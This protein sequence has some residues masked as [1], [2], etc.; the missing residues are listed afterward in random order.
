VRI[1]PDADSSGRRWSR[2][3]VGVGEVKGMGRMGLV[4][5]WGSCTGRCESTA[6]RSSTGRRRIREDA[7]G[8]K[9]WWTAIKFLDFLSS[10]TCASTRT[11]LCPALPPTPMNPMR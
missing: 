8:D 10:L 7:G 6:E 2:V 11:T 9:V 1:V 5:L 4:P 3:E